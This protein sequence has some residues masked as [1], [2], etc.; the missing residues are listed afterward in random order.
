MDPVTASVLSI[1][2]QMQVN[3]QN[4]QVAIVKSAQESG[5]SVLQLLDESLPESGPVYSESGSISEAMGQIL[6]VSA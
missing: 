2:M 5:S 6:N 4:L 1:G 3:Q